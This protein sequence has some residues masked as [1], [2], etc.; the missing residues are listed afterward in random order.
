MRLT[1]VTFLPALGA[2]V[3]LLVPRRAA[4]VFKV[5][6]L[7]VTLVTLL[8]AVP[9]YVGFDD[10]VADVQFEEVRPWM[11]GVGI[12]YH[13]GVDGI[14]LLLVLLTTFLMPVALASAWHAIEDR[15]KEFVVTMLILETGMV[16]VFV[17][18]DLFLFYVFW[19]AMLI[20][21]YFIIGVWGGT[22]RVYAAIKFVLYTMV[23]SVLMLVAILALYAQHGAATGTY[24]F[25]LPVLTRW[26]LP[27]GLAQELM[28][29]AFALAFAIK[30][31]LFPFHTWLPDAHVEAPTAGSVILAGVLLKMGTYGF[32]RFC[33]P[34]FP[35]ASL[36]FGPLVV[37]L[38]VIGIV[39]G[40]WVSTV[41]PD[42]KKL[43]AYSSVS[44]LG[45]VILGIFTLTPQGLVGGVLQMVNHGLST[46][47]LFLLV[48]MVYER[49]HT[50]LIADFGG[51]WSVAPAFS[52]L[53]LVVALSSLGLPG[54][55]G[56][57]G[58]FLI[59]VGAFQTNPWVAALATSGVIFAAVYLLWLCQRVIF[60][61]VTHEANR[62]LRDLSPREWT[63]L[64][65]V[66]VLIVWIGVYPSAL[67]GKTEATI[68]ALLAQ[69]Q[70]KANAQRVSVGPPPVAP[71]VRPLNGM[72]D[73]MW[74]AAGS[75]LVSGHPPTH[76]GSPR[77]SDAL[78]LRTTTPAPR[79]PLP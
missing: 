33:L 30:V 20:P 39:Y 17:S 29:L 49:R 62:G 67:T 14:S 77:A 12:S 25:D 61:A 76:S 46:G 6:G 50:R 74:T 60:G 47:A 63:L 52:S 36:V 42:M 18:L 51:L 15:W 27:P 34:L 78:R 10:R 11:P 59:L 3:L 37:A 28:F 66:V 54:L 2:L 26:V 65:P 5:G 58:E 57:V 24:T 9:L 21:M 44:H 79:T 72:R 32:L 55:N 41:Q 22:K 1:A 53:F 16:G 64:V 71:A 48:G 35:D 56:F 23:G 8:A 38:A 73:D 4:S 31:P 19:E 45:F 69:V 70:S 43:V 75:R 40:A 13:L 7:V 68:E